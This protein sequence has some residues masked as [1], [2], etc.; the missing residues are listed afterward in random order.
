MDIM[1]KRREVKSGLGKSHFLC[2]A[3]EAGGRLLLVSGLIQK[4]YRFRCMFSLLHIVQA[5]LDRRLYK[6]G[7]IDAL[8]NHYT[9]L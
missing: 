4:M 9:S 8:S 2:K 7:L 3:E 1:A 6:S 5:S